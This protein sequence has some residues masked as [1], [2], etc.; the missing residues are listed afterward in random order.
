M[1][2]PPGLLVPYTGNVEQPLDA[3][4]SSLQAFDLL[5]VTAGVGGLQ[6][7]PINAQRQLRFERVAAITR[8]LSYKRGLPI[9]PAD[10][11]HQLFNNS[12]IADPNTLIAEDPPEAMFTDTVPFDATS[13]TVFPGVIG[14]SAEI[15]RLLLL[16]LTSPSNG[17]PTRYT[18][19]MLN[20]VYAVLRLSD[21]IAQR[22]H[23]RRYT[24]PASD[25][26]ASVLIPPSSQ[27]RNLKSAVTFAADELTEVLHPL[28]IDVLDPLV[29]HFDDMQLDLTDHDPH[30]RQYLTPVVRHH[31]TTIILIP[32]GLLVAL[33]H[34]IIVEASRYR[35]TAP[36]S[37]LYNH[38]VSKQ[39]NH[40]L[41][42][43]EWTKVS[44]VNNPPSSVDEALWRFD[45]DKLAHTVV[46]TDSLLEYEPDHPF[47][48]WNTVHPDGLVSHLHATRQSIKE[49]FPDIRAIFSVLVLQGIGRQAMLYEMSSNPVAS[50]YLMITQSDLAVISRLEAGN[51]VSLWKFALAM[52]KLRESTVVQS[53]TRLDEFGLYSEARHSFY[54]TDDHQNPDLMVISP[55]YGTALRVE[56]ARRYDRHLVQHWDGTHTVEVERVKEWGNASLYSPCHYDR[57]RVGLLLIIDE[58]HVWIY[59]RSPNSHTALIERLYLDLSETIGYWLWQ[60]VDGI[61]PT[62]QSLLVVHTVLRFSIEVRSGDSWGIPYEGDDTRNWLTVSLRADNTIAL[63]FEPSAQVVLSGP[64]NS[65]ERALVS[66]LLKSLF[67][68]V[69][70]H[71]KVDLTE[72]IP[73]IIDEYIPLGVKKKLILINEVKQLELLPGKL[74]P[75]RTVQDADVELLLDNIWPRVVDDLDLPT[76]SIADSRRTTVLNLFVKKCFEELAH[77][78]ASLASEGLIEW[79]VR[80]HEATVQKA[81]YTQLILPTQRACFGSLPEVADSGYDELRTLIEC[82]RAIRFLIEYVSAQPPLGSASISITNFDRLVALSNQIVDKGALS[83]AIYFGLGDVA[84]INLPG[85]RLGIDRGGK[86]IAGVDVFRGRLED[87]ERGNISSQFENHWSPVVSDLDSEAIRALD[88]ATNAEFGLSM[89]QF[90]KFVGGLLNLGLQLPDEPKVLS[91]EVAVSEL[92]ES[93]GWLPEQVMNGIDMLALGPASSFPPHGVREDVYP[94][95]FNRNRSY[96]RRPLIVRATPELQLVWGIR[97]L[98]HIAHN[99]VTLIET[100]RL[101]ARTSI[102]KQYITKIRQR[103]NSAF[104]DRVADIVESLAGFVVRSRVERINSDRIERS[105]SQPLGDIDVLALDKVKCVVF[106]IE[107]K[108]FE[109]ARTPAEFANEAKKLFGGELSAA[110]R[111]GERI[112]WIRQHLDDVLDSFGV[113]GRRGE[114]RVEGL[115]VVSRPLATPYIVGSSTRVL[116][117]DGLAKYLTGT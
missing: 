115:I 31:N 51:P 91:M 30:A 86:Y 63:V 17:L 40:H 53:W 13:Y 52:G 105:R 96:V 109:Q 71:T 107:V 112:E 79:L 45:T 26:D 111:H 117:I 64:D 114:W 103:Q 56:D 5:D 76:G 65:G 67:D 84:L 78:V 60:L 75:A 1:V 88:D 2:T 32:S 9:L 43:M 22:A 14:D 110:S 50:G 83:D 104:N 72:T 28:S 49:S 37:E 102:M 66:K 23:L 16:A 35:L 87:Y 73:A 98:E 46:L 12:P 70:R 108:D 113:V 18:N 68:L 101:R 57:A 8:S 10:R 44:I 106:P 33:R 7:L 59:Q 97:Y 20:L 80:F 21:T 74:P 62:L 3:I 29:A 48:L 41:R 77:I 55:S 11:W 58:I 93:L 34:H 27:F 4:R 39:V 24:P 89:T 92:S 47:G 116:V 95:R 94:W 85:G 90:G 82:D 54:I 15:I 99:L 36:L 100:G 69:H 19:D 42:R 38:T 6:L 81:F 61:K 25:P